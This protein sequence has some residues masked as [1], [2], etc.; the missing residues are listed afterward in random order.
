MAGMLLGLFVV[1]QTLWL[2]AFLSRRIRVRCNRVVHDHNRTGGE[3]PGNHCAR[4]AI[5]ESAG[6]SDDAAAFPSR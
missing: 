5:P 1:N 3:A 4:S 6:G 2:W